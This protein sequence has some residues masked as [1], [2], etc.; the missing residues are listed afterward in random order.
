MREKGNIDIEAARKILAVFSWGRRSLGFLRDRQ[1]WAEAGKSTGIRLHVGCG[2]DIKKGWLNVD[3]DKPADIR[4]D[5]R[6]GLQLPSGCC[7]FIY[8]EHFIEH[9]SL[10]DGRACLAEFRRLLDMEGVLRVATPDLTYVAHRYLGEWRDQAWLSLPEYSHIQTAAEMLNFAFR[11]WEHRYLY[12]EQD[13]TMRLYQ[14]GFK[15]I[16]RCTWRQS[17]HPALKE[18]ETREDSLLIL[19]ATR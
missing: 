1:K 13:L 12:D 18:L 10:S 9:L 16:R 19:E 5:I 15:E 4:A 11:E 7:S 6:D 17:S 2:R 3:R 14:A 8:C